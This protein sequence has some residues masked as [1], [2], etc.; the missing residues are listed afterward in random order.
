MKKLIYPIAALALLFSTDQIL[1][2]TRS[3][4][5]MENQI[6]LEKIY[7]DLIS[8][9][10]DI[11]AQTK[12]FQ[13][14]NAKV[15]AAS[16]N[17]PVVIHVVY[18]TA[19]QNISDAQIN[20]Q[21]AILNQDFRKLNADKVNVPSAFASLAADCNINFC[22]AQQD[23]NGNAT[24]GIIR[25]STT[26]TS[27]LGDD[28]VKSSTTGGSNAWNTAKY[29]NIWVCNLGDDLLGYAQFPGGP[30]STDGV[31]ILHTAFGNI[32]TAAAPFNKGRTATHEVGHWLNLR[33]I[34]GDA[35]C[36]N[37]L[38]SDTPTQQTSNTGCP[39]F[40]KK[41][42]SNNGDMSM[43]YMDYTNDACMYMFTAGQ[44]TRMNALFTGARSGL[45][46]SLGCQAPATVTVTPP[47]G[48]S[49]LLTI[50]T[51]TNTTGVAPYGTYYM[52]ERTQFIITKA[53][54]QSAGF[55]TTNKFI[56]SLAFNAL[57][58]NA[59]T[60][61]GFTIKIAHTS[62]AAFSGTSF[63]SGSN[64]TTVYS[65]NVSAASNQWN[66]YNFSTPFM[67]NGNDNILIDICWNNSAYTNNTSVYSNNT[68]TYKTLYKRA[69][70]TTSDLCGTTTGATLTYSRPNM[71]LNFASSATVGSSSA[72]KIA[73]N[74]DGITAPK[75]LHA[76][77]YPNPF[78]GK[79]TLSYTVS[80]DNANG[81]IEI[82][83]LFGA[84]IKVYDI[85]NAIAGENN[86]EID[87]NNEAG[88]QH[89]QNGIYF[90]VFS[91]NGEKVTKKIMLER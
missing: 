87:F 23:P 22:L 40:P 59:Q 27:F 61:N 39:T 37:D 77:F 46:S 11:E 76:N 83:N 63:L 65:A 10:L 8:K 35:N 9:Q 86:L 89:L 45:V 57:T 38:V 67:Y 42:C 53:E 74:N 32:G 88:L 44:S 1:A 72:S 71:R 13:L 70:L 52:D 55:T 16:V 30:A 48:T 12:N 2:Q 78:A 58:A 69:D 28:Q 79:L 49:Q 14:S 7:P 18:K 20:S 5:S 62:S 17:I 31:V 56:K 75:D 41:T 25:K 21:I 24:N 36:G 82:Y 4:F 26:V 15:A 54:L 47:A 73:S 90:M 80:E 51:G 33:H 66:T 34:W 3:C 6:R 85:E 64:L 84:K 68:S 81:E 50:G 29:L 91:L 43:N 60:M 19:S